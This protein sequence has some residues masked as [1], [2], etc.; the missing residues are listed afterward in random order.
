MGACMNSMDARLEQDV[1]VYRVI[2][3]A[4]LMY[5]CCGQSAP[6]NHG[7]TGEGAALLTSASRVIQQFM[8]RAEGDLRFNIMALAPAQADD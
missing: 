8:S 6:I 4:V 1:A 2:L 3:C 5:G 7:A